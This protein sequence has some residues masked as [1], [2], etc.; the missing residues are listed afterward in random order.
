MVWPDSMTGEQFPSATTVRYD[1]HRTG[2]AAMA[3]A[4]EATHAWR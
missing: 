2:I 4:T 3:L 1:T